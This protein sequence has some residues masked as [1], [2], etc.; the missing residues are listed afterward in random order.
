MGVEFQRLERLAPLSDV[1]MVL[2]AAV[3][4][5]GYWTRVP[6]QP[7]G[8]LD[9]G[10]RNPADRFDGLRRVAPAEP[11]VQLEGRVADDVALRCGNTV[12]AVQ[13][14]VGAGAVVL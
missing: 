1:G 11:S 4:I 9:L 12:F 5:I 8:F 10:A 6:D 2:M 14:E 13:R 7:R 3:G